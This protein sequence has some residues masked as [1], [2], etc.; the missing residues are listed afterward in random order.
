MKKLFLTCCLGLSLV[1]GSTFAA[2]NTCTSELKAML[3]PFHGAVVFHSKE[4]AQ[5]FL[6]SCGLNKKDY[7]IVS[8]SGGSNRGMLYFFDGRSSQ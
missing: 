3:G 6:N 7:P 1:A 4:D 5:K 2:T 8:V